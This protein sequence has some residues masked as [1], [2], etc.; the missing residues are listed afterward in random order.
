MWGIFI[1]SSLFVFAML[2]HPHALDW[3]IATGGMTLALA[4]TARYVANLLTPASFARETV[5]DKI[6]TELTSAE[7][8]SA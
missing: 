1:G 6:G 5:Y 2:Y 3:L 7:H 8:P 4:A